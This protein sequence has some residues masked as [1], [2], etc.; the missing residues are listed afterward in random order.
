MASI[1]KLCFDPGLCNTYII[2]EE[3]SP[4]L[5]VDPGCNKNGCLNN[6]VCK[7]HAGK[8]KG[9]LLTH[10]HFDHFAGLNA[11]EKSD[12]FPLFLSQEDAPCLDDPKKNASFY[13]SSPIVLEKNVH[14]CFIEDGDWVNISGHLFE[15]ITTPFHTKGSVCFYFPNEKTVFTGD[16]LFRLGIG[17]DDLPWADP[18]SKSDSL[19][20]LFNL[21]L[22][23]KVAPGHGGMT[24]LSQEKKHL[25]AY[26]N[27]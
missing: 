11:F 6:Y 20:K 22:E 17:R 4:C 23:T 27:D 18:K 25:Q 16:T 1:T 15:V 2:G 7:H 26:L 24:T 21:P 12:S 9:V 10:G 3:G 8:I 14:P 5:I 19:K 13:L